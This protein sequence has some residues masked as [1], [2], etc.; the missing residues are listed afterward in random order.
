MRLGGMPVPLPGDV[1]EG[2]GNAIRY[3]RG[4]AALLLW[5]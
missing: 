3:L 1:A 4:V 5:S 2:G